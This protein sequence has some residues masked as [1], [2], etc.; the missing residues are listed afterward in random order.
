MFEVKVDQEACIGCG[1]CAAM[2]PDIFVMDNGKS[3][4]IKAKVEDE[5]SAK[6]AADG[7]P[8]NCITVE[9]A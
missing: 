8:V 9:K 3:K 7:C 2:A 1:A 5:S 6:D 4:V